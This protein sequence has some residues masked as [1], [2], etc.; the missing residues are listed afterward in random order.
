MAVDNIPGA[1]LNAYMNKLVM[2]KILGR[3][4]EFMAL[5]SLK[6]YQKYVT[7][8]NGKIVL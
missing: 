3:I 5:T 6:V 4:S 7:M 2:V 1:C 8:D